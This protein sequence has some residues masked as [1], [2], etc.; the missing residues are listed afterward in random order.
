MSR[1]AERRRFLKRPP[2][3][4]SPFSEN[5]SFLPLPP[6]ALFFKY[7]YMSVF[8]K[9]TASIV[10]V[11]ACIPWTGVAHADTAVVENYVEASASTGGNVAGAGDVI[12]TGGASASASI[13]TETNESQGTTSIDVTVTANGDTKTVKEETTGTVAVDVTVSA[14]S[15]GANHEIEI[16][17]YEATSSSQNASKD[18]SGESPIIGTTGLLESIIATIKK[19]FSYVISFFG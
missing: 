6:T 12:I 11:T 13:K 15:T 9:F 18:E 8:H 16:T 17:N 2:P 14:S 1:R 7:M 5:A 3:L 10:C 4:H 19:V